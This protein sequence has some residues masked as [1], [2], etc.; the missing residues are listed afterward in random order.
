MAVSHSVDVLVVGGGP[1]GAC[2]AALL[3]GRAGDG[4]GE[5]PGVALLEPQRPA[6]PDREEEA[7]LRVFAFS[8]ASERILASA[9]AWE[10][11]A[12]HRVSPYERMHVWHADEAPDSKSALTFDAAEAGEPN[13]GYIIENRLVQ[14]AL[15]AAFEERG[16][17]VASGTLIS[18]E[19]GR[20]RVR[21]VTS[22]GV[23][24]ARLVIGADGA[25]SSVRD[26]VG[27]RAESVDYQQRGLVAVVAT[28]RP[29]ARTAWQRF[30]PSGTLAFL[31][32]ADGTSSIVWSTDADE[33]ARLLAADADAFAGALDAAS[34]G[35]LGRTHL[36]SARQ[37]FPLQRLSA[38]RYVAERVALI[39]DAAHVVHPL[40]GQGVNLGLLDAACLAETILAAR[41]QREDPGALRVLRRYERWRRSENELMSAA[42]DAFNRFLAHGAGPLARLAQRGLG[43]VNRSQELKAVFIRRA[44]GLTGELPAAARAKG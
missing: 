31:P 36:R 41:S 34:D 8:R 26:A 1:V 40:A 17:Y 32:L 11:V 18:L 12:G 19:V 14:A 23:F 9:G 2:A 39:G 4:I 10:A 20:E 6:W 7:D 30:L 25:R 15:L 5:P 38:E 43:I 22:C 35:V 21:V 16:G 42:I 3:A 24:D 44:L 13:L 28:E 27:I 33:V 37:A 29:H